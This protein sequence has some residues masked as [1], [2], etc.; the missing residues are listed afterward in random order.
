MILS[1]TIAEE[2]ISNPKKI[3]LHKYSDIDIDAAKIL[4]KSKFYKIDLS[5][6]ANLNS[7]KLKIIV[8]YRGWL[9]LDGLEEIDDNKAEILA[10]H[11][12][13]LSLNSIKSIQPKTFQKLI[14]INGDIY[15]YGLK[16]IEKDSLI[17]IKETEG[18]V[19]FNKFLSSNNEVKNYLD[20]C[21]KYK[22]DIID[23]LLT[24]EHAMSILNNYYN[25]R[26]LS[27]FDTI[28]KEAAKYLASRKEN[29]LKLNGIKRIDDETMNELIKFRF[30]NTFTEEQMTYSSKLSIE[31]NSLTL[32]SDNALINLFTNFKGHLI[33]LNGLTKI[34]D[35][36]AES[37]SKYRYEVFLDGVLELSNNAS[38]FL[39]IKSG[40]KG[41]NRISLK[42]LKKINVEVANNLSKYL[43]GLHLD[44][45]CDLG[46]SELSEL[47]KYRGIYYGDRVLLPLPTITK[48]TSKMAVEMAKFEFPLILSGLTELD[49]ECAK[50]LSEGKTS[51]ISFDGL[52]EISEKS[53]LQFKNK[54]INLSFNGI[55]KLNSEIAQLIPNLSLGNELS[56]KE[57]RQIR[58]DDLIHLQ[59]SKFNLFFKEIDYL[60]S[61]S[62]E[63]LNSSETNRIKIEFLKEF[64]VDNLDIIL[65]L[66]FGFLVPESQ[67][68]DSFFDTIIDFIRKD[69]Y[70]IQKIKATN[71]DIVKDRL[72]LYLTDKKNF[73]ILDILNP[74]MNGNPVCLDTLKSV[75]RKVLLLI[76]LIFERF[77][78]KNDNSIYLNNITDIDY[79]SL[80]ELKE[81]SELNEFYSM[82]LNGIEYLD[83]S[84]IEI[85]SKCNTAVLSLNSLKEVPINSGKYL[86][87]ISGRS[88]KDL[89][90]EKHI[91]VGTNTKKL[92]LNGLTKL[93]RQFSEELKTF[94]GELELN[95]IENLDI[96]VIDLIENC[97]KDL[98]LKLQGM[99]NLDDTD[100]KHIS[101]FKGKTI[102]L[103]NDTLFISNQGIEYLTKLNSMF[104]NSDD[105][106]R[107]EKYSEIK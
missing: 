105:Y 52:L 8:K 40:L 99:K 26:K 101:N 53:L 86:S 87:N 4:Q 67:M 85:L 41:N 49:S 55:K 5:G 1:K 93:S 94:K 45:L 83:E 104:I 92:C 107:L 98:C 25:K 78:S 80:C 7:D 2:F 43:G 35:S 32:V 66:G 64:P 97:N 63:F 14:K 54:K 10:N 77:G 16:D 73:E 91:Q 75:N 46:S 72:L 12:G 23:K 44:G 3:E 22:I 17:H 89:I 96:E 36:V 24:K 82:Q 79:D 28:T 84:K 38:Y 68:N 60:D 47:S 19:V 18:R 20:K 100:I 70:N 76:K 88:T 27:D 48:I 102:Y 74:N 58:F 50:I 31:L 69:R 29:E 21:L 9:K 51:Y 6:I 30:D 42:G 81:I 65:N 56:F 13:G 71:L 106:K 37:I 33:R 61:K 62:L 57:I 90:T 39:S 95:G 11:I 103:N 15:L 34:S 59:K